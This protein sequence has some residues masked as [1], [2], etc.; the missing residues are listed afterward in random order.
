MY[1]A[2]VNFNGKIYFFNGDYFDTLKGKRKLYKTL[3]GLRRAFANKNTKSLPANTV[4][5]YAK[6]D[7]KKPVKKSVKK[8]TVKKGR[9]KNPVKRNSEN[10]SSAIKRYEAFT[11]SKAGFIDQ[12]KIPTLK[13]GFAFGRC[14]GILYTTVINGKTEK[15]IHEFKHSSRPILASNHDGQFIALVGGK[16]RFTDRGI[17]DK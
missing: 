11:E 9:S 16:Y 3:G 6:D 2:F 10:I 14:D 15:F 8:K 5:E 12:L 17:V 4:I 7:A 13:E 1:Y